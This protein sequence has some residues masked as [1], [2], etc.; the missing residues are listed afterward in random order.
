MRAV[1]KIEKSHIKN[2]PYYFQ[3]AYNVALV[4]EEGGGGQNVGPDK[5]GI[6]ILQ[7]FLK[8]TNKIRCLFRHFSE[9]LF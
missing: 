3:L 1:Y 4:E 5:I 7:L 8:N 2:I 9:F 6:I